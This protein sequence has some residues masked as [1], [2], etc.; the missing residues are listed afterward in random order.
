M[1]FETVW[2]HLCSKPLRPGKGLMPAVL[3]P[4]GCHENDHK[5]G[6]LNNRRF[7]SHGSG[8]Q[9]SETKVSIELHRC[10]RGES[11]LCLFRPLM[12]ASFLGL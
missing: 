12:V 8:G 6:G 10:S 1:T 4:C 3:V 2:T 9:R 7:L 11:I 5:L